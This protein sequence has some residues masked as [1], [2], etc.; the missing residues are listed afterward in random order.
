MN[1][2]ERIKHLNSLEEKIKEIEELKNKYKAFVDYKYQD[3]FQSLQRFIQ[4]TAYRYSYNKKALEENPNIFT[5][6]D[7]NIFVFENKVAKIK[8][9]RSSF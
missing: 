6:I 8:Y 9:V 3:K 1:L 4:E 7:D 5:K 2:E